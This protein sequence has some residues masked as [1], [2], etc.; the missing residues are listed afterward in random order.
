MGY[1]DEG[2]PGERGSFSLRAREAARRSSSRQ[3][4]ARFSPQLGR[5]ACAPHGRGKQGDRHGRDLLSALPG[6]AWVSH[7]AGHLQG[8]C[9]QAALLSAAQ[10][11]DAQHSRGR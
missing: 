11:Q 8:R 1:L 2:P 9:R 6:E 4:R 10:D 5:E 7:P 3:G